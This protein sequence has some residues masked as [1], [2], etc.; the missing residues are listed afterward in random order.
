MHTE[1]GDDS[2]DDLQV[3]LKLSDAVSDSKMF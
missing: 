1:F 3:I 2:G